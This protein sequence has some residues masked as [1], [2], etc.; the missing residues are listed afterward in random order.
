M[1]NLSIEVKNNNGTPVRVAD[2]Q[3]YQVPALNDIVL[4]QVP[5]HN[6]NIEERKVIKVVWSTLGSNLTSA[7]I[8][9]D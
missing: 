3:V 2:L 8:I 1:I 7:T 4:I 5:F 6:N 9:H